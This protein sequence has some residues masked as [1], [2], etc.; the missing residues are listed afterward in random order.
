MFSTDPNIKPEISLQGLLNV[1]KL[2]DDYDEAWAPIVETSVKRC[3]DDCYGMRESYGY[4]CE[5]IPMVI[6]P[7]TFCSSKENFLKCPDQ[8]WNPNNLSYCEK[9]RIFV[10][11]CVSDYK[12]FENQN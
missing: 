4:M 5:V 2:S 10:R 8:H 11:E 6:T 9:S 7:V 12:Q 3:F 1:I